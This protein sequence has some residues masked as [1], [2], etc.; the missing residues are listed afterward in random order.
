[1]PGLFNNPVKTD[2]YFV[3]ATVMS[4]D[5]IRFTCTVK[6]VQGQ[7]LGNV[8]WIMPTG[9]TSRS[10]DHHTPKFG[11]RVIVAH[12]TGTPLILGHLSRP[13][14]DDETFPISIHDGS[15]P[16]DTGSYTNVNKDVISNPNKPEDL[17]I[18]DHIKTS[19]GG[20]LFGLLR[21]GSFIAKASMLAQI[22]ITK[23]D[24]L[25]RVV[26]RNWE[27]FTDVCV[28]V[29]VSVRGQIY[30]YIGYGNKVSD[31]RAGTFAYEEFYGNTAAAQAL[32][33]NY[34]HA[35]EAPEDDG[36]VRKYHAG[37]MTETLATGGNLTRT[38]GTAILNHNT[39]MYKVSVNGTAIVTIVGDNITV[40]HTGG[41]TVTVDGSQ[42][43]LFR[44]GGSTVTVTDDSIIATK[45]ASTTTVQDANTT[46]VNGG[47]TLTVSD[48]NITAVNGGATLT[49][50]DGNSSLM[51][52]GHGVIVSSGGVSFQ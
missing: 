33:D 30:R 44:N 22:F 48:A 39:D 4:V 18:G 49:V 24:D 7:L 1:M 17:H 41:S 19:E 31:S 2:N 10:G 3:E 23:Y 45:G 25:V 9:G 36:I 5:A 47:S 51:V 43:Q 52:G 15:A 27:L 34:I 21:G 26:G 42:I 37:A 13:G 20:G 46:I 12:V 32:K 38:T 35:T 8:G 11:D 28:D 16:S 40:Q 14:D 6:T 50:K 29:C